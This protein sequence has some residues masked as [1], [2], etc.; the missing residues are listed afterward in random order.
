MPVDLASALLRLL[1]ATRADAARALPALSTVL[2]EGLAAGR[3]AWPTVSVTDERFVAQVASALTSADDVALLPRLR[4]ADLY[5][6]AA[7]ADADHGAIEAL[8]ARYRPDMN[9][10]LR[11]IGLAGLH[12]DEVVLDLW[13][14]M[15][16]GPG[17]GR[18]RIGDYRGRGDLRR[19]LRSSALRAAYKVLESRGR[20]LALDDE[21]LAAIPDQAVDPEMG[22]LKQRYAAEFRDA[23][24]AAIASLEPRQR[25]LLRRHHL[26]GLTIDELG[27]LHGVHRATAAR[28]VADAR[29]A[30]LLATRRELQQRLRLEDG[31]MS[32]LLV[33]VQSQ[34]DLSIERALETRSD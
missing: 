7:C 11:Q 31:E 19:W 20:D 25:S 33:L 16:V 12:V 5:L 13:Q 2:A 21:G 6:T 23:F 27:A 15:F 14:T 10:A 1:D 29:E 26:D 17:D 28:W 4:L 8:I 22:Y 18:P 32:S 24:H 34:L 9:A 30:V 3:A